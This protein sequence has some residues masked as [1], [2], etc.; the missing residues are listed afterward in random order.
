MSCRLED[1][2]F[3]FGCSLVFGVEFLLAFVFVIAILYALVFVNLTSL[4]SFSARCTTG[5]AV[6]KPSQTQSRKILD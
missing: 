2:N 1:V 5:V 4:G 3:L 6:V